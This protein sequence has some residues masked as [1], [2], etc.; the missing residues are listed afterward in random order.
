MMSAGEGLQHFQVGSRDCSPDRVIHALPIGRLSATGQTFP[1]HEPRPMLLPFLCQLS[2]ITSIPHPLHLLPRIVAHASMKT[3]C[4]IT[5]PLCRDRLLTSLPPLHI[6]T[7]QSSALPL[8]HLLHKE[9]ISRGPR[10]ISSLINPRF[11]H[12]SHSY[13]SHW[14]RTEMVPLV[15]RRN[16]IFW[17]GFYHDVSTPYMYDPR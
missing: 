14:E 13:A 7:L 5:L 3:H 1:P 15:P 12:I 8:L 2:C 17:V 6:H 11:A 9:K 4:H 16:A 10:P